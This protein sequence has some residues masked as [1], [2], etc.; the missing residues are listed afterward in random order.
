MET[1]MHR[2]LTPLFLCLFAANTVAA[3]AGLFDKSNLAAWCIVPFDAHKR[4]PEERAAMLDKL[5]FTKFVYDL[6][7]GHEHLAR[8]SQALR[9]MLPHLIC[10]NLNGMSSGGEA[11]AEKILPIGQG[12]LDLQLLKEIAASGYRG[13]IGILNHTNEDAEARL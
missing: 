7:H 13:P 11:G 12:E 5:G 2:A 3:D 8:F 9:L 1:P 10:I 4:A 6:H